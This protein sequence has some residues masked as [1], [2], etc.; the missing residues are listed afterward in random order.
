MERASA[1]FFAFFPFLGYTFGYV[2]M[3]GGNCDDTP[4]KWFFFYF[5]GSSILLKKTLF[6]FFKWYL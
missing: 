5:F 1:A 6:L 2:G 3:M 4:L